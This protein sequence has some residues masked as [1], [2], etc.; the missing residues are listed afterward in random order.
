[1]VMT[2]G[3]PVD[4]P[5]S[6]CTKGEPGHQA[7]ASLIA[8]ILLLLFTH[9]ALATPTAKLDRRESALG[10]ALTLSI[11]GPATAMEDLDTA[12]LEQDFLI[13][14][15]TLSRSGDQGNLGL[16]LYPKRPG[17][18]SIPALATPAGR[19]RPL[20]VRVHA[21]SADTPRVLVRVETDPTRPLARQATRLTL[22]A[23][24]DGSLT[25][26][27]PV[28]PAHEGFSLRPLGEQE[29]DMERDGVPCTAHRWHWALLPTAAGS[30]ELALPWLKA[31]KFGAQLRF[32]PPVANV[33]IQPLPAWLPPE[34][35]IGQPEVMVTPLPTKWPLER[36][37]AWRL[38]ITGG[39]GVTEMK[40]LLRMQLVPYPALN[41]YPPTVAVLAPETRDDPRTH[42]A[43]TLSAL[44][45]ATGELALPDLILPWYDPANGRLEALGLAGPRV[46]IFNPLYA[47]LA[48]WGAGLAGTALLGL[49]GWW[50]I[51]A[52][53]W[54]LAR[55]RGLKA[56]IKTADMPALMTAVRAFGLTPSQVLPSTL[57]QWLGKRNLRCEG[58]DHFVGD[59]EQAAYGNGGADYVPLKAQAL[60]I[61]A[62]AR[63]APNARPRISLR[64]KKNRR[65]SRR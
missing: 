29:L 54:R 19:T 40:A 24:D 26:E 56:I 18:L 2:L 17:Q 6:P 30:T 31:G 16:T 9:A 23:C 33:A 58:L 22:E 25:W 57:G 50:T 5:T 51:Q 39:Y 41:A 3:G 55:R 15:R 37:L 21:G 7:M 44:P 12:P 43:V 8:L 11:T 38:E 14:G 32:P 47:I 61:L 63:P 48:R 53:A 34:A 65:T 27:R 4:I 60:M 52:I 62:R 36:P 28:L 42:L 20:P 13:Q 59:L 35:A 1:M 49:A 46:N 64:S 45:R 10:E